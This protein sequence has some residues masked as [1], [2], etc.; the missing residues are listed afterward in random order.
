MCEESDDDTV[1]GDDGDDEVGDL[2][3]MASTSKH[4][5]LAREGAL[6][7]SLV[8]GLYPQFIGCEG[9]SQLLDPSENNELAFLQL[10][11]PTS[12]CELIAVE[13]DIGMHSKITILSGLMLVPMKFE[14]SWGLLY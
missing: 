6:E 14:Y 12:L 13:T 3:G 5:R 2:E 10:V 1:G 4:R 8:L 7:R 9:L 11:W